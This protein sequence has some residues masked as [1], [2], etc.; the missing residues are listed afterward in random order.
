MAG[1]LLPVLFVLC[2]FYFGRRQAVALY[3]PTGCDLSV[4]SLK[5]QDREGRATVNI[6]T[7]I[8]NRSPQPWESIRGEQLP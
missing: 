4:S 3:L 1:I 7:I 8:E 5:W 2:C 6:R